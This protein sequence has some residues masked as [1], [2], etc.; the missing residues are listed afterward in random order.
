MN[1]DDSEDVDGGGVGVTCGMSQ[2]ENSLS[3]GIETLLIFAGVPSGMASE[4]SG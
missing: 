3:E 1:D 2:S 4:S